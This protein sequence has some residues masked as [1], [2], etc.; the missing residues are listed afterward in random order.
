MWRHRATCRHCGQGSNWNQDQEMSDQEIFTHLRDSHNVM[1]P[2]QPDDYQLDRQHQ[3]DFCLE[4]R[5]DSCTKCGRDFC[6][7][8]TGDIDGLCGGCI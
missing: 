7:L 8:H 2:R 3:C 6:S 1:E 4:P 5:V